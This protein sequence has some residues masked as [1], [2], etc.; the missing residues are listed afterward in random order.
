MLS[1][2]GDCLRSG[3]GFRALEGEPVDAF[4]G[5]VCVYPFN[6]FYVSEK[7]PPLTVKGKNSESSAKL[8]GR[9]TKG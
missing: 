9:S 7:P 3:C 6:V 2:S 4:E 8:N 5:A 1:R